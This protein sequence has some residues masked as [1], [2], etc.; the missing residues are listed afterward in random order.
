MA[1]GLTPCSAAG[2]NRD[3]PRRTMT[4]GRVI[5]LARDDDLE[6]LRDVERA[7]ATPFRELG[8]ALV[9]DDAPPTVAEL[10]RF[11]GAGRAWV[12]TDEHDLPVAYLLLDIVDGDAHIEQVSVHPDHARQQIGRSLIDSAAEWARQR[13]IT[14]LTLTS[15]SAVPW[16]APYYLR[17][18]F[19]VVP[20]DQLGPGLRAVRRRE[21]AHGLDQWARVAMR[22]Q[23]R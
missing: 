12:Y 22:R 14:A 19:S 20:P 15:Y 13:G 18:G 11:S 4:P 23:L 7:A 1:S 5:R 9:A 3:C 6:A 21:N 8:M 16:N 10:A 17:L 2:E